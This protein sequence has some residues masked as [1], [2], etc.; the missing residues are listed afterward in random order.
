MFKPEYINENYLLFG[1]SGA[2]KLVYNRLRRLGK[3][4]RM[5]HLMSVMIVDA[6]IG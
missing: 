2:V 3:S 1:Y 4:N 6:T 5:A